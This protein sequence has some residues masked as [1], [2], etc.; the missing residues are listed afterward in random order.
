[1]VRRLHHRGCPLSRRARALPSV[2]PPIVLMSVPSAVRHLVP[3]VAV[4]LLSLITVPAGAQSHTRPGAHRP[5]P[6]P[7]VFDLVRPLGAKRGELEVNTLL[8]QSTQRGAPLAWAPEIEWAFR[9]GLAIEGELPLENGQL[10]TYKVALQGTLR[11]NANGP[12]QHG[13]QMIGQRVRAND[14]WSADALYLAGYRLRPTITLFTMSGVRR[15]ALDGDPIVQPVQ[16]TTLFYQPSSGLILG[17]ETNFL[18]GAADR[19]SRLIMPQVQVELA[20]KYLAEF[21]VGAE[22]R[23]PGRWGTAFGARL[24]RQ[25]H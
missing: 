17:V 25:L 11:S 21:G 1:M 24:V 16:N 5:M 22:E 7:M 18:L 15:S 12:F 9:D 14:S 20:G 6:E 13:W 19:R 10:K 2:P 8:V 3:L 23:A 4:G